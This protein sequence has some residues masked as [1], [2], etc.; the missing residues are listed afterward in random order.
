MVPSQLGLAGFVLK[1]THVEQRLGVHH[2][3]LALCLDP[4]CT[5]KYTYSMC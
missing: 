2:N 5:E 4:Y 1:E 3:T